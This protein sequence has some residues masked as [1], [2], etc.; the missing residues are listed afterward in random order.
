MG[1]IFYESML[2]THITP[3]VT[4]NYEA[5][6]RAGGGVKGDLKEPEGTLE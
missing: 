3:S 5:T 1:N 4:F 6:G 2:P